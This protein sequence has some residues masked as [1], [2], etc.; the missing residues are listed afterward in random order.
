MRVACLTYSSHGQRSVLS[1]GSSAARTKS[2]QSS[3]LGTAGPPPPGI[4]ATRSIRVCRVCSLGAGPCHWITT[5]SSAPVGTAASMNSGTLRRMTGTPLISWGLPGPPSVIP[6]GTGTGPSMT[7]SCPLSS[8]PLT[9][10]G[11]GA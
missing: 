5:T 4:S 6:F 7:M 9:A 3:G 10:S 11:L 8:P 2:F 1:V